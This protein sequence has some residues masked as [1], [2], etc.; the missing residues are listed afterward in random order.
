[1]IK[2]VSVE[3]PQGGA[4]HDELSLRQPHPKLPK[5]IRDFGVF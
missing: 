3:L 4:R 1:M 2:I 5:L